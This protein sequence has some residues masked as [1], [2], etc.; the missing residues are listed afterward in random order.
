MTV[1][2]W[3]ERLVLPKYIFIRYWDQHN[4]GKENVFIHKNDTAEW[5]SIAPSVRGPE[6]DTIEL[7]DIRMF[8]VI[9]TSGNDTI[10]DFK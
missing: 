2:F 9:I 4:D 3:V 6:G 1:D 5:H 7:V 10:R 8:N